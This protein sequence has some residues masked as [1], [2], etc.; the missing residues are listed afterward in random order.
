M[1]SYKEMYIAEKKV[2]DN[3]SKRIVMLKEIIE[4]RLLREIPIGEFIPIMRNGKI[5]LYSKKIESIS[6]IVANHE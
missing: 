4:E 3:N 2:N 5:Y 1:V 6:R